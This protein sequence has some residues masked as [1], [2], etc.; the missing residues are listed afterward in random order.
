MD[1]T[2]RFRR[3]RD[4]LMSARADYLW[5]CREFAW[6][7]FTDFNW[8][9]DWFAAIARGNGR[10]ALRVIADDGSAE[11]RSFDE[12]RRRSNRI[13]NYLRALGLARR[14]SDRKEK[15]F[16]EEDFRE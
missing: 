8:A 5:A 11:N 4:V 13:A 9:I 16:W 6:P 12:L 1:N 7:R 2:E 3:A 14:G 15:E 10:A